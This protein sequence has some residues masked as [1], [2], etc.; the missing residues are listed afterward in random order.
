MTSVV[1][2][3]ASS[4]ILLSSVVV[5]ICKHQTDQPGFGSVGLEKTRL[6]TLVSV[7]SGEVWSVADKQ[8]DDESGL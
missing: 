5:L 4:L 7:R 1:N 2:Q 8:R 6:R 3:Q